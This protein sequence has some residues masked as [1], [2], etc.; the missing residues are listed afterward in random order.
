MLVHRR[1]KW[2]VLFLVCMVL[3]VSTS[4]ALAF[5]V[6]GQVDLPSP[7]R[8]AVASLLSNKVLGLMR[9]LDAISKEPHRFL[10]DGKIVEGYVVEY[11]LGY[12]IGVRGFV[13]IVEGGGYFEPGVLTYRLK[14][15]VVVNVGG[16]EEIMIGEEYAGT[17][18][19]DAFGQI[20][21]DTPLE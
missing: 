5:F 14:R 12:G 19:F 21:K 6:D 17:A 11:D 15:G 7:S 10:Y 2:A 20:V 4:P 18:S 1:Q 16:R 8:Q 13:L 3:V 9:P